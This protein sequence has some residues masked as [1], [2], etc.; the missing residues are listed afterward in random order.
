MTRVLLTSI[1]AALVGLASCSEQPKSPSRVDTTR[2]LGLKANPSRPSPGDRLSLELLWTDP[3]PFCAGTGDDA[4]GPGRVCQ[5]GRCV[6]TE[7]TE[8][9]WI[10]IPLSAWQPSDLGSLDVGEFTC[11]MD[12]CPP[13]VPCT[14]D[15]QC[16]YQGGCVDG[17]CVPCQSIGPVTVCCGTRNTDRIELD[18]PADLEVLP[19]DCSP[20]TSIN[21]G[22]VFQIQ[23]QVCAGGRIDLCPDGGSLAFGCDGE[24]ATTASATSRVTV[25]A[26]PSEA[27]IAPVVENPI[28]SLRAWDEGSRR[29]VR[30]CLEENCGDRSCDRNADCPSGQLCKESR[31]REEVIHG[32]GEGASEVYLDPCDEPDPCESDDDCPRRR[33]CREGLCYRIESPFTGFFTTEGSILPARDILDDDG[34]GRPDHDL[35]YTTWL[36]PVLDECSAPGDPCGFGTCDP[37][38]GRCTGEVDFWVV[39]RDGRGGQDW[40]QRTL[41]IIP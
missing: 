10:A 26:D 27:N 40:I 14:Q 39:I 15:D 6:R 37:E 19:P 31:C 2:I 22:T 33:V 8:I 7:E 1:L 4:C 30:G 3:E 9:L 25:V 13:P 41:R 28:F 29:E 12:R 23:A 16:P 38:A 24:G 11:L 20:D 21:T 32:M 35:V 36:P 17:F 5:E 18:V 34:D